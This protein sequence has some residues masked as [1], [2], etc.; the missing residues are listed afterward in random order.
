MTPEASSAFLDDLEL[1]CFDCWLKRLCAHAPMRT[2]HLTRYRTDGLPSSSNTSFTLITFSTGCSVAGS[3]SS[4][5][6]TASACAR[7]TRC[8]LRRFGAQRPCLPC[9]RCSKHKPVDALP[10]LSLM[11]LAC[12]DIAVSRIAEHSRGPAASCEIRL[13]LLCFTPCLPRAGRLLSKRAFNQTY[14]GM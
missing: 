8:K 2:F 13:R 10:N 11:L 12:H 7:L 6:A 9:A 14:R 5:S 4:A 1:R 3:A